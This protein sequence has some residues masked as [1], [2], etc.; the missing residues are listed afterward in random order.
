MEKKSVRW[1]PL[2]G[3]AVLSA[4]GRLLRRQQPGTALDELGLPTGRGVWGLAVLCIAALAAFLVMAGKTEKGTGGQEHFPPSVPA[5]IFAVLG[6]ALLLAGNL[7]AVFQ[8]TF[9][10]AARLT[11]RIAGAAGILTTLCFMGIAAGWVRGTRTAPALYLLPVVY[12]ILQ[13]IFNFKTWSTDPIILDYCFKL[14]AMVFAMLAVFHVGE[15]AFGTGRRRFAV[16]LCLGGVFFAAVSLADGGAVH[17]L[18]TSGTALW[19]LAS[20]WQLLG[21]P[22]EIPELAP[23]ETEEE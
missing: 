6:A 3:T 7:L 10:S 16:F 23:E 22:A 9:T 18:Q 11:S 20:V 19:L 14:F 8:P 13:L 12:Y 21:P 1:A 15:F 5:L 17:L 2:V 4:A